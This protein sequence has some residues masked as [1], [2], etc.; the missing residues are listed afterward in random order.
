MGAPLN[1]AFATMALSQNENWARSR[2]LGCFEVN[3]AIQFHDQIRVIQIFDEFPNFP[4]CKDRLS[5]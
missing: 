2:K 3:R 5:K 4:L 1:N